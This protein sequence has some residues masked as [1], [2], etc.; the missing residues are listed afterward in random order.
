MMDKIMYLLNVEISGVKSIKNKVK[1]DF[2]KKTVDKNFDSSQYRVKAIYGENGA[3]K[4]AL[5]TA[6]QIYREL[7]W[8]SNYLSEGKNQ[9]F[10]GEIVNKI[11]KKLYI[12]MEFLAKMTSRQTVYKYEFEIGKSEGDEFQILHEKLQRKNGNYQNNRYTQVFECRDGELVYLNGTSDLVS[13]M[14]KMTANLLSRQSLVTIFTSKILN[15]IVDKNYIDFF[16]NVL[17]DIISMITFNACISVYIEEQDQHELYFWRKKMADK[18]INEKSF[19]D[20]FSEYNELYKSSLGVNEKYISKTDFENYEKKIGQLTEFIKI[21]KPGLQ[22]IDIDKRDDGDRY[23]C[24]LNLN[25]GDYSVNKEFEST[26]IKKLIRLFDCLQFA[27]TLGI[28]FIDELDSNLNDVYLCKMIEYFMYYGKGQLCF[29]THNI[30]PMLVLRDNK[31]SIDFLTNENTIVPWV[32]KGNATPD[33]Y[34]RN[35]MIKD[36]PFNIEASDFVG[37]LGGEE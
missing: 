9:E 20:M 6:I 22:C 24:E 11:T 4:S 30:D 23:K 12:S 31:N 26:G 7:M 25:Y 19:G 18:K 27:S 35:G 10:L 15:D 2:Y 5:V 37:I 36:L 3:G 17:I 8:R 16:Q 28:V 21:F 34:Y 33:S 1:L 32:A 13:Y 14:E 29:T